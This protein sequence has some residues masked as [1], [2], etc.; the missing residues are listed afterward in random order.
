M[1][2]LNS[3][4]NFSKKNRGLED[5]YEMC[6]KETAEWAKTFY[7]GTMLLPPIKRRAIWAIYVWCRRTDELMDSPELINEECYDDGWMVRI[8]LSNPDDSAELLSPED[9]EA[10]LHEEEA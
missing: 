8:E 4:I 1:D 3:K 5:A 7:L 6:R 10:F 2:H 9:Y